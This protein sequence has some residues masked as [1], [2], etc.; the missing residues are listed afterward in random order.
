[1]AKILYLADINSAH[2]QKWVLGALQHDFEVAIFSLS[3]IQSDWFLHLSKVKVFSFN[4]SK[5]TANASQF[6]KLKYLKSVSLLKKFI[7]EQNPDLLHAHYATSYG[8]LAN[9]SGFHPYIL[10]AWGSDVYDFPKK[11]LLHKLIFKWNLKKA[12]C[13]FS[14]SES[15]AKEI[16]KYVNKS[17]EVTPFGVDIQV[18]K[19]LNIEKDSSFFTIGTI[20]SLEIKYGIDDLINAFEKLLHRKFDKDIRLLIIGDGTQRMQL[21]QL[22]KDKKLEDKITFTGK[23]SQEK[24]PFYHQQL[25][26]FVALSVDD[27]ESFGVSTI[28]AMSCSVPVVVSDVSGFK[29]VVID[30]QC[31]FIVPRNN[32]DEAANAIEKLLTDG[33]LR[34]EIGEYGREHV[35][36]HYDWHK[37]LAKAIVL[38]RKFLIK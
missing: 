17:I 28:E 12:D 13:I 5:E 27:S 10:S 35:L 33:E 31:G 7:E 30:G 19:K 6:E 21:E 14:T 24:V 15:M 22:V 4:Q 16:Q 1:M 9:L 36:N 37:N 18:F 20:K 38:Y 3:A 25:D 34:R 29:E 26:V 8:L 2:T 23:I 32:P 11:S